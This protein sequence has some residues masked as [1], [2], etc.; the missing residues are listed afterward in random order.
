MKN[1][2][3]ILLLLGSLTILAGCQKSIIYKVNAVGPNDSKVVLTEF[4]DLQCP[5]CAQLTPIIKEIVSKHPEIRYEYKHYPLSYHEFSFKAAEAAECAGDQGKF[6][7]FIEKIFESQETWEQ[8][9]NPDAIFQRIAREQGM[10]LQKLGACVEDPRVKEEALRE[11]EEGRGLGIQE[12]PTFFV[13][14]NK[15]DGVPAMKVKM[16]SYFK[17]KISQKKEK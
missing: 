15:I 11:R 13:N 4:A 12:T 1:F 14:G 7:E 10:D 2:R 6:W 17:K 8:S 3:F 16:D 5:A 9:K